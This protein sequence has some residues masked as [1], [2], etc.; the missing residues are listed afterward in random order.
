ML[1]SNGED[2]VNGFLNSRYGQS[3]R[4]YINRQRGDESVSNRL[5]TNN[6]PPN[7]PFWVLVEVIQFGDLRKLYKYFFS[8]SIPRFD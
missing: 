6:T 5:I 7:M 2:I 4:D 8:W 3:T 1:P